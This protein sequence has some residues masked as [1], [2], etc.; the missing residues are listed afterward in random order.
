MAEP[1]R[2]LFTQAPDDEPD[3]KQESKAAT[4]MLLLGLHALSQRALAAITDLFTLV[5]VGLVFW[6]FFS[7]PDP[8]VHQLV[9]LGMFS[10]F[11]LAVN[12]I[13]RRK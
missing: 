6:L 11:I 10:T 4:R 8:N 2:V 7:I 5:T 1:T 13:A 3:T 12:V 9:G